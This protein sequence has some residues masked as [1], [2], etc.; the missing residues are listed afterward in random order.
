MPHYAREY[1]LK[2][3]SQGKLKINDSDDLEEVSSED[4]NQSD[5]PVD[6]N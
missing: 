4:S 1:N 3:M 6:E 2:I 5:R